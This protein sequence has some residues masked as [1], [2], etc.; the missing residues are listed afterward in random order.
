MP[1]VAT[2]QNIIDR[3]LA[4][5][6]T[7]LRSLPHEQVVDIVE[8]IRSHICDAAGAHGE[9]TRPA[10]MRRSAV[11]DRPRHWRRATSP[12]I[13]WRRR[14]EPACPGQSCA[15]FSNGR[16]SAQRA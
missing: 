5:L 9:I 11:W 4:E 13:C 7:Q 1:T 10:S 16:H 3:Y 8:E 15:G 12:T 6:R 14:S 2:A